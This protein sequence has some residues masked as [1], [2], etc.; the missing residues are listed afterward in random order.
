MIID[1]ETRSKEEKLSLIHTI[2]AQEVQPLLEQHGGNVQIL[3]I[4]DDNTVSISYTGACAHCPGAR[5]GTL[6]FIQQILTSHVHPSL[7]INVE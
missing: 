4:T 7:S 5:G 1:W 3:D 2:F 6:S